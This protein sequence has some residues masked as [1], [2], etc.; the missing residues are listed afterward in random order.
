ML[1]LEPVLLVEEVCVGDCVESVVIT[2]V[3]VIIGSC[4][5]SGAETVVVLCEG[6]EG[7][8]GVDP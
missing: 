7:L 5:V 2:V 4:V 8:F 3:V 6:V 1:L